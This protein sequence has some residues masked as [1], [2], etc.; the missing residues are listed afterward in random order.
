M[1]ESNPEDAMSASPITLETVRDLTP[2][3]QKHSAGAEA[4]RKMAPEVMAALVDAGVM[5]M[6]IPKAYGGSEMDPN[7]AMDMMEAFARVDPATGQRR[8]LVQG[9]PGAPPSVM[10]F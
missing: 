1:R 10:G 4:E 7:A 2:L 8:L 3:I 6:W 5:R 9:Q